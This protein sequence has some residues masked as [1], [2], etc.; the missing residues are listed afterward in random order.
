MKGSVYRCRGSKKVLAISI[1]QSD[2]NF[3]Y[4]TVSKLDN[5]HGGVYISLV[6]CKHKYPT[7][8]SIPYATTVEHGVPISA[9]SK[10]LIIDSHSIYALMVLNNTVYFNAHYTRPDP[11]LSNLSDFGESIREKYYL[12]HAQ[13][14]II[15]NMMSNVL[16]VTGSKAL[17]AMKGLKIGLEDT[18][19]E[20]LVNYVCEYITKY[21][22]RRKAN[23]K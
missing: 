11:M 21:N 10:N 14:S 12:S 5:R 20:E 13:S 4:A 23:K 22:K 8:L 15:T 19:T 7:I 17:K 16:S 18:Y 9:A 1:S 6:G 3:I 2:D